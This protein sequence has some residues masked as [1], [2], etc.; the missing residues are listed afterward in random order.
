MNTSYADRVDA[1]FFDRAKSLPLRDGCRAASEI[2]WMLGRVHPFLD[3]NGH[4]QRFV[5]AA[6]LLELPNGKLSELW[7]VYPRP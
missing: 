7:R 4:I 5:F 2:F 6:C 1:F 3:G